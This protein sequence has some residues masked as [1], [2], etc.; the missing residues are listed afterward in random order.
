MIQE[1]YRNVSPIV[2]SFVPLFHTA[3]VVWNSTTRWDSQCALNTLDRLETFWNKG[4]FPR[5][6]TCGHSNR[7]AEKN[8]PNREEMM[9]ARFHLNP[10]EVHGTARLELEHK[11][12]S[13]R[14]NMFCPATCTKEI[15]L[16]NMNIMVLPAYVLSSVRQSVWSP[17]F[18]SSTHSFRNFLVFCLL[19]NIW[20]VSI[21][22]T[23]NE[24]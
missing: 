24:A 11:R 8:L 21:C 22:I 14:L 23:V 5:G 1:R 6:H 20:N 9:L 2:L 4:V 17:L 7:T 15:L 12:P 10:E 13:N 3:E 16:V 19:S 18:H